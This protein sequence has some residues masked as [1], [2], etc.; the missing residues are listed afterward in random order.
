MGCGCSDNDDAD[1]VLDN[2]K[3]AVHYNDYVE[4]ELLRIVFG[5]ENVEAALYQFLNVS[6]EAGRTGTSMCNQRIE[7]M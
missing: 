1:T 7:R 3:T 6:V 4:P 5:G 2:F